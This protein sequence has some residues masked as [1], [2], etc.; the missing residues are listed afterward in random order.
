MSSEAL[1]VVNPHKMS[2]HVPRVEASMSERMKEIQD[3]GNTCYV[4]GKKFD[5]FRSMLL[6]HCCGHDNMMIIYDNLISCYYF[7]R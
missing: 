1:T 7:T 3:L 5:L 2:H 4:C 6:P